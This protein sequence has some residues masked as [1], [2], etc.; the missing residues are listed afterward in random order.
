MYRTLIALC[1]AAGTAQAAPPIPDRS[2]ER[3]EIFATCSG[4][5][6][7]L[8]TRQRAHGES[9]AEENER[10]R[11]TFESLVEATLPD[12]LVEGIGER[13][14]DRWRIGGWTEMAM[15]LADM[16]HGKDERRVNRARI[17]LET[18]IGACRSLLLS[19]L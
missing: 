3:V 12:A 9:G 19:S 4:R 13:Q 6:A 17:G 2:A 14:P 8:A 18:R 15:M 7:A 16:D 11:D 1:L 5:L 10:L